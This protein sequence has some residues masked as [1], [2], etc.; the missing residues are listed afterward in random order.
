ML[1]VMPRVAKK[2]VDKVKKLKMHRTESSEKTKNKQDRAFAKK[3][4]RPATIFLVY[5]LLV[6]I[7]HIAFI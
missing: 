2:D 5:I 4:R 6:N 7:R 3:S 1:V